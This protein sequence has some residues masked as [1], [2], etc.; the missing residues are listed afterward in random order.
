MITVLCSAAGSPGVTTTALGLALFAEEPTLL[1]DVDR[2]ASQAVLAG[3]LGGQDPRGRGIVPLVQ[4]RGVIEDAL[5]YCLP[6]ADEGER[7]FLPGFPQAANVSLFSTVWSQLV[8]VLRRLS[9]EGTFVVVDAGRVQASGLPTPLVE[10]ADVVGIVST[11]SLR[12]LAATRLARPGLG[13]AR[14]AGMLMVGPEKP[15]SL[16]EAAAA[17]ELEPLGIVPYHPA[18][19]AVLSDGDPQPS[20]FSKSPLVR[21][22]RELAVDLRAQPRREAVA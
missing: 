2:D 1:V 14:R 10:A 19:A 16:A 18:H 6:L 7:A 4:Q 21:A 15:Y 22:L 8:R 5:R 17:F 12:S 13:E 11:A 20:R 9:E 3:F